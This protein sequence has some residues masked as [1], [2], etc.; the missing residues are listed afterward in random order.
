M[1]LLNASATADPCKQKHSKIEYA[2]QY[3]PS[4][5]TLYAFQAFFCHSFIFMYINLHQFESL[6][7][8]WHKICVLF[9]PSDVHIVISW[10][11]RERPDLRPPASLRL[12][13]N[14]RGHVTLHHALLRRITS[15]IQVVKTFFCIKKCSSSHCRLTS[16]YQFDVSILTYGLF[17]LWEVTRTGPI[18]WSWKGYRHLVESDMTWSI[19]QFLSIFVQGLWHTAQKHLFVSCL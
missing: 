18:V 2:N 10:T 8:M 16:C 7:S 19:N 15:L 9:Q 3:Q 4:I 6:V 14:Q 17:G 5:W 1:R 13:E 11:P 12:P